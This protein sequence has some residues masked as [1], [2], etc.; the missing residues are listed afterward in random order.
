MPLFNSSDYENLHPELEQVPSGM[1]DNSYTIAMYHMYVAWVTDVVEQ[2]RDSDA[3]IRRAFELSPKLWARVAPM[4]PED[5]PILTLLLVASGSLAQLL[6][7]VHLDSRAAALEHLRDCL[8]SYLSDEEQSSFARPLQSL[9]DATGVFA[10]DADEASLLFLMQV[11]DLAHDDDGCVDE[12]NALRVAQ[13][14]AAGAIGLLT[15]IGDSSGRAHLLEALR[16]HVEAVAAEPILPYF[17]A[18]NE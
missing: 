1:T 9:V 14:A 17:E 11:M 8:V 7:S 4:H 2:S 10:E 16:A 18:D 12:G 5:D 3:E 6:Q 15:G 13:L